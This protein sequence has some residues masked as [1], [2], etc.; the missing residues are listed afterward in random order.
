M[1]AIVGAAIGQVERPAQGDAGQAPDHSSGRQNG[2]WIHALGFAGGPVS[3]GRPSQDLAR[4]GPAGMA[5]DGESGGD[6]RTP[7]LPPRGEKTRPASPLFPGA[8]DRAW[9]RR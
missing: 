5:G 1:A 3:R 2:S 9:I 4:R 7:I 6:F 8:G